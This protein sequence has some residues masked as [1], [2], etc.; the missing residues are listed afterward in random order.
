MPCWKSRPSLLAR[1]RLRLLAALLAAAVVAA[2]AAA[3]EIQVRGAQLTPAEDAWLLDAEFRIDLGPRLEEVVGHGVALYFV[4]EFELSR[5][6]WYWIDERVTGRTQTW[7]LAYNAL[8]RQYRLS[9]GALHQSFA[10]LDEALNV[11][12]RVRNWAVAER[13]LLKPGEPYHAAVRLKLDTAQLPKPFQ[14]TAIGNKDWNLTAE[15][16]RWS[17]T[18]PPAA[19]PGFA[20]TPATAPG[21]ATTPATAPAIATTPAAAPASSPPAAE[22]TPK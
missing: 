17:F 12:S 2:P 3:G 22:G 4:T 9:S 5:P 14:V 13:A 6:R 10:T 1:L 11:L 8:T 20:T 18:V 19:A 16:R 7:R 15:I 21:I